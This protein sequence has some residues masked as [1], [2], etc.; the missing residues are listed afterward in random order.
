M[1]AQQSTLF[2]MDMLSNSKAKAIGTYGESLAKAALEKR[3]YIVSYTGTREKRGDLR[4]ITPDGE[5]LRV[6]VKTARRT[7]SGKYQFSLRRDGVYLYTSIDHA[8]MLILL[9]VT[10][11]GVPVPFVI[12]VNHLSP[13]LKQISMYAP[14]P[15]DYHGRYAK[16]R[17]AMNA[18]TL[19]IPP[20]AS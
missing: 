15:S 9:A 11:S 10:R 5:L 18:I 4:V 17:Q 1:N 19:E 14:H 7:P 16:Y 6:E 20:C 13:T 3:G 8:D 2:D 12:P